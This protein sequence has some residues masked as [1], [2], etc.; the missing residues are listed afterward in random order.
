ML[1]VMEMM[2]ECVNTLNELRN[3]FHFHKS[4]SGLHSESAYDKVGESHHITQ[5]LPEAF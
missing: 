1:F 3:L 4:N 5:H 2:M